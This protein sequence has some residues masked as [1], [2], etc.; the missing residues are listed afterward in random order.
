MGAA[1]GGDGRD[2]KPVDERL[3][4]CGAQSGARQGGSTFMMMFLSRQ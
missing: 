2:H 3:E 4:F 1:A